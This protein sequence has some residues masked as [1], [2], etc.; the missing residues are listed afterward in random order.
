MKTNQELL[1][2]L[3]TYRRALRPILHPMEW[4]LLRLKD[5]GDLSK[6]TGAVERT[7][8][9]YRL[10]RCLVEVERNG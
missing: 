4:L 10:A 6:Y 7:V 2:A 8:A 3:V 5:A 9:K 1:G